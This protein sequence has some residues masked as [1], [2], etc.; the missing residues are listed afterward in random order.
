MTNDDAPSTAQQHADIRA[1]A[2]AR[3]R[4]LLWLAREL[5]QPPAMVLQA[6]AAAAL[7]HLVGAGE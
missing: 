7:R 6:E 2:E 3:V 1:A 4:Y 5:D